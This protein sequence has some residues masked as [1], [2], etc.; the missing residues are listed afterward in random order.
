MQNTVYP[1]NYFELYIFVVYLTSN[2]VY[3]YIYI[4]IY[5]Y[6]YSP[7][8]QNIKKERQTGTE[9]YNVQLEANTNND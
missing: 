8:R 3:I 9:K 1:V 2:N 7:Q 5:I 6:V 4:Y